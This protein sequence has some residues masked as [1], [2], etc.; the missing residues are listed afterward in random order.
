MHSYRAALQADA[1]CYAM[2]PAR[3]EPFVWHLTRLLLR[4]LL[5]SK[6]HWYRAALQ[7]DAFC[8]EAFSALVER[9]VLSNAE[10]LALVA[11]LKVA[12]HDGWLQV[13]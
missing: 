9:H 3:A 6:V 7:A 5:Q 12:P 1:F 10:E 2:F 13:G 8:Y 11:S 4:T